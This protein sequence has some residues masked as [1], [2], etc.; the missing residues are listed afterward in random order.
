MKDI[1][2]L[3]RMT[4]NIVYREVLQCFKY[5]NKY[6]F[7]KYLIVSVCEI[8]ERIKLAT[9]KTKDKKINLT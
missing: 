5:I 7:I 8:L 2:N 9:T 1:D 3:Q 6:I 4:S